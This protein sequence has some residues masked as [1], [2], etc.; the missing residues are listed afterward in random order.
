MSGIAFASAF[1]LTFALTPVLAV[2][3]RRE[4]R[5]DVPNERSSHSQA[6][7]RGGGLACLAGV[8]A[9]L[10]VAGPDASWVVFGTLAAIA[11]LTAVGH[12]DDRR[13]LPP[14]T[15]LL[16]QV[17]AGVL[18][19]APHG[20]VWALLG[21][22]GFL[23]VVN[24]VNFMDGIN[25]ITSA[26][27][28]TWG[29]TAIYLARSAD[30]ALLGTLGVV[31]VA[32]ALAF[33]PW[34]APTARIFL[35]DVGSYLYGGIVSAGTILALVSGVSLPVALS[36]LML[37]LFDVGLTLLRR[38]R[39]RAPLFTAHREHIYQ[40]LPVRLGVTHAQASSYVFALQVV[41]VLSWLTAPSPV[42]VAATGA[43]LA[44]YGSSVRIGL[45][46]SPARLERRSS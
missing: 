25:G 42:A 35:G 31:A 1:V 11:V 32:T 21:A 3:L 28:L 44:L 13:S 20:P 6:I 7:P 4:G 26:T 36:P 38:I 34:N 5:M 27:V 2:C 23:V 9:G 24:C 18:A 43:V 14:A 45:R 46:F 39:R 30:I 17:A 10:L 12:L 16:A 41:V 19:G 37:Y 22:A 33:L 15:R 8:L 40:Q 29:G